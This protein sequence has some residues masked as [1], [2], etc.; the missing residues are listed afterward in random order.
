MAVAVKHKVVNA[1]HSRIAAHFGDDGLDRFHI[2]RSS[3]NGV[4]CFFDELDANA[5]REFVNKLMER[6]QGYCAV[7]FGTEENGYKYII[8]SKSED[9]RSLGKSFNTALNGRGGGKA[10]M[11]QG[12]VTASRQAIRQTLLR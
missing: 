11:I 1:E 12:S 6:C 4:A 9:I 5:V 2:R 10:E 8:G 3:E 7:F